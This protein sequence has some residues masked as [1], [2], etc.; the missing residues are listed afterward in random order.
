VIGC[1]G[2]TPGSVCLLLEEDR[3]LFTGD[4]INHHLWMQLEESLP[5]TELLASLERI[6]WVKEKADR[7]L[8]GHARG[9]DEIRLLDQLKAGAAELICQH[10][11][12]NVSDEPYPWFGG[13]AKQHAFGSDGSVICYRPEN[14]SPVCESL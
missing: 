1:A 11:D 12:G 6:A 14:V 7:I 4:A 8:H 9:F 5:I 2:H 3:I 10:A 13:V